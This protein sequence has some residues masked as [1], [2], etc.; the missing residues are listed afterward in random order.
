M[1]GTIL[2]PVFS[3]P[4]LGA[5][6][7]EDNFIAWDTIGQWPMNRGE[8]GTWVL[9]R[10]SDG[11]VG[12]VSWKQIAPLGSTPPSVPFLA[13]LT[14]EEAESIRN[15]KTYPL[16]LAQR[17]QEAED[18]EKKQQEERAAEAQRLAGTVKVGV[19]VTAPTLAA[20][21]KSGCF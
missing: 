10:L 17:Q 13:R 2:R 15:D 18:A 14:A 1:R 20:R 11:Q 6:E 19:G 5:A 9:A 12:A 16:K 7:G 21:G 8:F 4:E 3:N